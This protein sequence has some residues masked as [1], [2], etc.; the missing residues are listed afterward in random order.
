MGT[1]NLTCVQIDGEYKIAK[2][3][4]WD[5]YPSGLG[6]SLLDFLVNE[7][8][9]SLPKLIKECKILTEEEYDL[10]VSDLIG[11]NKEWITMEESEIL[12]NN[13]PETH[14]DTSGADLLK[15]IQ[16][17]GSI[18]TRNGIDFA[19]DSLFCEWCYVID[20]DKNVFEIY[21]GFNEQPLSKN[22]RFFDFKLNNIAGKDVYYP[23]SLLKSYALNNL[24]TENE[25]LNDLEPKEEEED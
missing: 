11:E 20:F 15:L 14:R 6:V 25:F 16:E 17:K 8:N 18:K 24:P 1:R 21:K 19:K 10:R 5:G 4:Q 2:Y 23:V 9:N 3:G 22:D 13:F 12:K 7:M